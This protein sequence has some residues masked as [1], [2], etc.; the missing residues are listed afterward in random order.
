MPFVALG[1]YMER[2]DGQDV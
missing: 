1:T 2:M